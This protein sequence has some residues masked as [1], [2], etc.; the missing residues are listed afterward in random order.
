MTRVRLRT[1]EAMAFVIAARLLIRFVPL[2]RWS[3]LLGES[4]PAHRRPE[5]METS[6]ALLPQ[7]VRECA[8]AVRR[9]S[10][11]L[12]ATLCLPQA[13]A[14]QWMLARR[15]MGSTVIVGFLPS[16]KSGTADALHA[17]LS[18]DGIIVIGD[19]GGR[20]ASL[21]QFMKKL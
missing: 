13:V 14:L 21:L 16:A 17:W 7:P 19:S 3:R 8:A 12:P 5:S 2:S 20:H 1:L 10:W 15:S 11:R 4:G 6:G 9:A 18:Y